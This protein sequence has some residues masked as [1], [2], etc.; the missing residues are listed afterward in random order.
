MLYQICEG[1]LTQ[2]QKQRCWYSVLIHFVSLE[3][4]RE[5]Q[6]DSGRVFLHSDPCIKPF[7]EL[8]HGPGN[9][10]ANSIDDVI[11]LVPGVQLCSSLYEEPRILLVL[12]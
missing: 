3:D 4:L 12:L 5:V 1:S 9:I 7:A 11:F 2:V 6:I 8:L 10:P